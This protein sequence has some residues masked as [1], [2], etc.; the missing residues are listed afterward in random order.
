[1][2]LEKQSVLRTRCLIRVEREVR[3]R[4]WLRVALAGAMDSGREAPLVSIP[5]VSIL[6][7]DAQGC[8]QRLQLPKPLILTPPKAEAKTCAVW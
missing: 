1:M 4:A 3:A 7:R 2:E 6:L 8:E 5:G